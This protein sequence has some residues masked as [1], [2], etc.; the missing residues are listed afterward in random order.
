MSF[1]NSFV[2]RDTSGTVVNG[3]SFDIAD[4]VMLSPYHGD[5][6]AMPVTFQWQA[7][8]AALSDDYEVDI[9]DPDNANIYWWTDPS[10]GYVGSYVLNTLPPDF[11]TNKYYQWV[12]WV[13][14][15]VGGYGT[16]HWAYYVSFTTEQTSNSLSSTN[17]LSTP[18]LNPLHPDQ[19]DPD[20]SKSEIPYKAGDK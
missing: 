1:W 5:V 19:V 7:R 17:H 15:G 12:M 4:V 9:S 16:S 8:P 13:Y 2:I 10:L 3:G 14:D 11:V 6:K 18:I 20:P